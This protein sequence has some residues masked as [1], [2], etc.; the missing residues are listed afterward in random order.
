[1]MKDYFQQEKQITLSILERASEL[2]IKFISCHPKNILEMF[3]YHGNI[4]RPIR[5]YVIGDI[6]AVP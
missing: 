4:H 3:P 5:N 1:M 2:S 6:C